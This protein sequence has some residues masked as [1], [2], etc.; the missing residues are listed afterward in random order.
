[1]T[2]RASSNDFNASNGGVR[3]GYEKLN[4]NGDIERKDWFCAPPPKVLAAV[5][6]LR[7]HHARPK[8]PC[9]NVPG[10]LDELG[11]QY[12]YPEEHL[13][14]DL[15]FRADYNHI[16]GTETCDSCDKVALVQHKTR[17]STS[18][19]RVHYDIIASGSMIVRNGIERDKTDQCF[20]NRRFCFDMEAAGLMSNFPR[21]IIR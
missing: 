9:N 6:L 3:N 17:S 14:T 2:H 21:V 15:L 8:D 20:A 4:G 18:N 19:T 7:A 10:I 13:T 12:T 5:D 16:P 11:E 1:M